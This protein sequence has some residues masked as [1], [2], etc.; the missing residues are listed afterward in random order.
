MRRRHCVK[1]E[2]ER[3]RLWGGVG[4]EDIL[5]PL[6]LLVGLQIKS[7]RDRVTGE[8]QTKRACVLMRGRRSE[9]SPKTGEGVL[10]I[11]TQ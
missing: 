7:T 2:K 3:C 9:N 5:Y 1:W 10:W 11:N 8:H 4:E 6:V